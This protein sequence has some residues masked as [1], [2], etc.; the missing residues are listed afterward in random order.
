[1]RPRAAWVLLLGLALAPPADAQQVRREFAELHMGVG[2]RI[3]LYSP[4][5]AAAR[6]AAR[7]AFAR[8]AELEDVMSDYRPESEL[9]RL[10]RPPAGE[11]VPVSRE[12]FEVLAR[13]A[14]I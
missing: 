4:D 6:A 5:E 14:E 7:A 10:E 3:V 12:L 2:V 9:R 8:I 1:M 11:W 13:A